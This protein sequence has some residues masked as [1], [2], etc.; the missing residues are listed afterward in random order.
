[1]ILYPAIDLK[2]GKCVRLAEGRMDAVTVFNEDPAAQASQFQRAGFEWIHVVDLDGATSGSPKNASAV[3]SILGAAQIPVQIG[4][5][6]RTIENIAF[7]LEAGARRVILGTV[8]VRNPALVKE[9]AKAFPERIAVGIDARGGK[10]AL[11]GWV[12]QS[13]VSAVDVARLYEDA[14]VAAL[15]VTDIG[16]DGLKTGVN[17]QLTSDMANAVTIPVIASGGVKSVDDITQLRAL[18]GRAIHGCILG[19]ALYDGDIVPADAIRAAA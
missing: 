5:G 7:W 14:G 1:M 13:E 9:A 18:P 2:D 10:V 19:R 16:R 15:I 6:I 11:E 8:A 3:S 12:E 17:L 4:G